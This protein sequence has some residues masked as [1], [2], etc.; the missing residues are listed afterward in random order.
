LLLIGLAPAPASAISTWATKDGGPDDRLLKEDPK[1]PPPPKPSPDENLLVSP[2]DTGPTS[3]EK[4]QHS[5]APIVGYNPTYKVFFGGGYFYNS[6]KFSFGI[7]GV[8]TFEKVYQIMSHIRHNITP[9]LKYEFE[10]EYSEG[11]EPYYGEGGNTRVA[12]LVKLYGW[13]SLNRLQVVYN[14]TPRFSMAAFV[15]GRIRYEGYSEP[16]RP[17]HYFPNEKTFGIGLV[18]KLDYR[19]DEDM[20]RKGF[21]QQARYTYVPSSF[22]S[23]DNIQPFHQIEG[24]FNFYQEILPD[25]VAAV[26]LTGGYSF[27]DPS[28][29][30]RYNLGGTDK[31]RGYL[32]NRFR[33]KKY[34]LEQTEVRFP[35]WD[36]FSGAVHIGFGDATDSEFESG[37]LVY[38]AGLLVGLPP[39]NVKKF[40]IDYGTGKDESGVFIDFGYAF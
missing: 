35:I 29:L 19:D 16:A 10:T 30:F 34:Y 5:I 32:Y 6:P 36:R 12:D 24:E 8:L 31:L 23:I 11:F 7:H 39:D 1:N 27:G 2:D 33:G 13:K 3:R 14:F 4:A 9:N 25:V 37:K 17:G 26:N 28:Y 21:I 15:D 22:S 40:R 20:P 38:G 18:E